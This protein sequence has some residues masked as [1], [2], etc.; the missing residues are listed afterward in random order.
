MIKSPA[1]KKTNGNERNFKTGFTRKF[2]TVRIP[3]TIIG[4][5]KPPSKENVGRI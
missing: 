3:A 2:K 5:P 4:A 1:L